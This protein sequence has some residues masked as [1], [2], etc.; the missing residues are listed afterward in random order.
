MATSRRAR[1]RHAAH[2]LG[3]HSGCRSLNFLDLVGSAA[4]RRPPPEPE[5]AGFGPGLNSY[6]TDL[7]LGYGSTGYG[8][9][10]N[11]QAFM[12]RAQELYHTNPWVHAAERVVSDKCANVQWHLEDEDEATVDDQTTNTIAKA[13]LAYIKNP[14]KMLP[15]D[16]RRLTRRAM[17]KLTFRHMGLCG[18]AF[19]LQDQREALAGTALASI[20][21]NPVRMT[22]S[23]DANGNLTGW[24][25]DYKE[26]QR[27][28]TPLTLDEVIQFDLDPADQGHFGI[29]LVE[30]AFVKANLN[31]LADQ[32]MS[33]VLKSGG[34]LAGFVGPK[35]GGAIPDEIYQQL[36][37]DL[38][39]VTDQPDAAKRV[40]ALQ[41]PV[42]FVPNAATPI[43][44]GIVDLSKLSRDDILGIWGVPFSQIG[45]TNSAGLNSG[46]VRKYDEAALWQNAC[47]PRLG[48]FR[49]Q[50]Q[51]DE[52]DRYGDRG[53]KVELII[54][55]PTFD[56]D[57]PRFDLL[58]KSQ[59]TPLRNR[60]RRA[61]INLD[62]T[63]DALFDEA[64]WMPV[65]ME[66]VAIVPEPDS[67]TAAEI[68][69]LLAK[70]SEIGPDYS[71]SGRG[72]P[73]DALAAVKQPME[74]DAQMGVAAGSGPV[75]GTRSGKPGAQPALGV[76]LQTMQ[77]V[78]GQKGTQIVQP[79]KAQLPPGK[80]VIGGTDHFEA[81]RTRIGNSQVPRLRSA[82]QA[83]LDAQK[84]D[85]IGRLTEHGDH[86]MRKP[87]DD[88]V[89]WSGQWDKKLAKVIQPHIFSVAGLTADALHQIIVPIMGKADLAGQT[90]FADSVALH[91][92]NAGGKRISGINDHTRERV[93]AAI[94]TALDQPDATLAD[95]IAAVDAMP[96][97]DPYR[98][99]TIARTE[100]MQAYNAASLSTYQD[101]NVQAVM[102]IDGDYDAIC[103]DRNGQIFTLADAGSVDDHPNGTLD[104]APLGDVSAADLTGDA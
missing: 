65:T 49:E 36:V 93:K 76:G 30:A 44:L 12:R 73:T 46:D 21:I 18:S 61:L 63:G 70:N 5:K 69:R 88:S 17:W 98:A 96:T 39:N 56:D 6:L 91:V 80:R 57:S 29:G 84:A 75:P 82:T 22:P 10:R 50:L 20:Y 79:G 32:H 101:L 60:E 41:G 77:T 23:E 74:Q 28:G 25:L 99:E 59:F 13:A 62:P 78:L 52:I 92:M 24:V 2:R 51:E 81:L 89:W 103:A 4:V 71:D 87:N 55:E 64:V 3:S 97:F 43:Q 94:A 9:Q 100:A 35:Q 26:Q 90:V 45:G 53:A 37:R 34:R 85:I 8:T 1:S 58:Q 68:A 86:F 16:R 102:A 40:I 31:N 33:T 72:R 27:T 42:D 66:Q 54:D 104:W 38:R 11:I 19:W 95:V 48:P 15:Q 67:E 14:Q 83:F 7:P 47:H